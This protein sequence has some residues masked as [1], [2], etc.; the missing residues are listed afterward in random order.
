MNP[1]HERARVN[2]HLPV[3]LESLPERVAL[4][5]RLHSRRPE[6]ELL[7]QIGPGRGRLSAQPRITQE[8]GRIDHIAFFLE[9]I[10]QGEIPRKLLMR[11]TDEILQAGIRQIQKPNDEDGLSQLRQGLIFGLRV[12]EPTEVDD[13]DGGEGENV[14]HDDCQSTVD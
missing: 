8:A 2:T 9:L 12:L 3:A 11:V 14:R 5:P 6:I 4:L 7:A 13:G 1:S 10:G